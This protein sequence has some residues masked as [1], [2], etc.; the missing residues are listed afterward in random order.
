MNM[1]HTGDLT[2]RVFGRLTV[3]SQAKGS[4][5]KCQCQ[6]G[7][8]PIETEASRLIGGSRIS[9]GCAR[10][11]WRKSG[12]SQ[13]RHGA[14]R[15]R[16]PT[17][18]YVSWSQMKARCLNPKHPRFAEWG[19]RGI[20]VCDRWLMFDNF[21]SDM[22]NKPTRDHSIDRIDNDRGYSLDNCRWA[23]RSQQSRNK[24]GARPLG[25]VMPCT[26]CRSVKPLAE[27]HNSIKY[28]NGK[29][30]PCAACRN[31]IKREYN[32]RQLL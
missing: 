17:P 20:T 9:C 22:G 11:E 31:E 32:R 16:T 25:D 3:I 18:E 2:G 14:Y 28:S 8:K 24:R 10:I 1:K 19:G 27:F 5:W 26:R 6:C 29:R 13:L 7:S 12:K 15:N 21:I 23:T 4:Y 30:Q